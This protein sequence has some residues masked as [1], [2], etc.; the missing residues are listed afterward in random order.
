M[1]A[2]RVSRQ[3]P[4][5]TD[6]AVAGNN[7]RNRVMPHRLPDGLCGHFGKPFFS[8]DL[9]GNLPVRNYLTVRNFPQDFPYS[10]PERS[11]RRGKQ[12]FRNRRPR[13][14]EITLQPV[15]GLLENCQIAFFFYTSA[16]GAFS[17]LLTVNPQ[18]GQILS[19]AGERHFS[20]RGVISCF[21]VHILPEKFNFL[22]GPFQQERPL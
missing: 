20:E 16:K 15:F 2:A 10:L 18:T 9:F 4:V 6:H 7:N 3:I 5:R 13:T 12:K 8:G 19:V 11:S 21:I 1:Y 14:A 22:Q 17:M